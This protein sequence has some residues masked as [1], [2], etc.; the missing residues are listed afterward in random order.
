MPPPT[1]VYELR[2]G[3]EIVA[4]GQLTNDSAIAVGDR[5]TIAGHVGLVQTILLIRGQNG[6]RLVVQALPS[7]DT[8]NDSA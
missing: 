3:D 8:P 4:T 2:R 5:L 1:Y 7:P 6:Q